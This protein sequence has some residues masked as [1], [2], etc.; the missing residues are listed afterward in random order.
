LVLDLFEE[1]AFGGD[2]LFQGG[3]EIWFGSGIA[4]EELAR[5]LPVLALIEHTVS[6]ERTYSS[7]LGGMAGGSH[8]EGHFGWAIRNAGADAGYSTDNRDRIED[9]TEERGQLKNK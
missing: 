5:A 4:T 9:R 2:D 8:R 6:I 7:Q 1:I 3:L